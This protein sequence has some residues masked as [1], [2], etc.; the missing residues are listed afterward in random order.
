MCTRSLQ[1]CSGVAPRK[2]A[3]KR[4]AQF[5]VSL[6]Q[7]HAHSPFFGRIARPPAFS[8]LRARA[9]RSPGDGRGGAGP[10]EALPEP[11]VGEPVVVRA[12]TVTV[13]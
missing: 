1:S 2:L 7:A 5:Y 4:Q 3:P 10:G 8:S 13:H 12:R 9:S 11:R 6:P